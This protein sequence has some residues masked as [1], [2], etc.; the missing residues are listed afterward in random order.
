MLNAFQIKEAVMTKKRR[1]AEAKKNVH[2]IA[3]GGSSGKTSRT[4][5]PR[6]RA[7]QPGI[8]SW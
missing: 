3:E 4:D 5:R 7:P 2:P 8:T 6:R 1:D